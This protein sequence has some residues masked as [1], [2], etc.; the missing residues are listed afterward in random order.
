[1]TSYENCGGRNGTAEG[2]P[3]T[4]FGFPLLIEIPTLQ[5]TRLVTPSEACEGC[6]QAAHYH[7]HVLDVSVPALS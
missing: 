7:I 5:N 3:A 6:D 1:M 2:N 4:F